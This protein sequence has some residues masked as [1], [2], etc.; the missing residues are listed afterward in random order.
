MPPRHV[1]RLE[2]HLGDAAIV[3]GDEAV[4]DLGE[5]APLLHAE[6]PHDAEID[7][8]DAPLIVDEQISRMHVGME[9]AVAHGVAEEGLHQ[10]GAERLQVVASR[11]QGRMVGDR[12]AVDPFKRQRAPRAPRPVDL[13][14]AKT[15]VVLGVLRDLGDGRSLHTQIHL[16]GDRLGEGVDHGDRPQAARGTMQALDHAGGE[17]IAV[18]VAL[19]ALLDA[20]PEHLHRHR[21]ERPVELAHLR[22][23]HLGDR[24]GCDRRAELGVKRVDGASQRIL[25][26]LPRLG[27]REGWEAILKRGEVAGELAPD[28]VVAGGEE[29]AELDVGGAERS[30]RLG[31]PRLVGR[32]S[33]AV[34]AKRRGH[35]A[36]QRKRRR[37]VRLLGH[38]ARAAPGDDDARPREPRH[39]GDRVHL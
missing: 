24:G 12:N 21:L 34:L 16:D 4:Q 13:R 36:E 2:M 8:D 9:E 25:D 30:E 29:L 10:P 14:Y 15:L 6:A 33:R 3:A 28:N 20:G 7:G 38:H 27:L 37:Q 39:I 32:L 26:R 23:V 19:E 18:E 1:A 5:E 11:A 31:E 17:E 35:A 22:L